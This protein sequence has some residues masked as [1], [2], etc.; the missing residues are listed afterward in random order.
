MGKSIDSR[1][2]QGMVSHWLST[3]ENG[4]LGSAYGNTIPS[5][6]FAPLAS[7]RANGII[8]KLKLDVPILNTLP[9][10]AVNLYSKVSEARPDQLQLYIGVGGDLVSP[11][12]SVP[13][14]GRAIAGI[15][16]YGVQFSLP[17]YMALSTD[18][19]AT[20]TVIRS[21]TYGGAISVTYSTLR[22]SAIEGVDFVPTTGTLSW[23]DGDFSPRTFTVAIIPSPLPRVGLTV[24]LVLT[25][26]DGA[27]IASLEAAKLVIGRSANFDDFDKILIV[28]SDDADLVPIPY[29]GLFFPEG[30]TVAVEGAGGVVTQMLFRPNTWFYGLVP[31]RVRATGSDSTLVV[32]GLYSDTVDGPLGVSGTRQIEVVASDTDPIPA[33]PYGGIYFKVGGTVTYVD[34]SGGVHVMDVDSESWFTDVPVYRINA[35]GTSPEVVALAFTQ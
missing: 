9:A 4:Y 18:T 2:I 28:P 33:I 26:I 7:G 5:A 6:L 17:K 19:S 32:Y 29:G 3:P 11:N 12:L 27:P 14:R 16:D 25:P 23:P 10:A 22:G 13:K 35:T 31:T 21:G 34:F 24:N 8:S 20:I 30:G 15:A 1:D